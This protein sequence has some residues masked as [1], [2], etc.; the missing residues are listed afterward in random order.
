MDHD[1][2]AQLDG[3]GTLSGD[4]AAT[5]PPAPAVVLPPDPRVQQLAAL[6]EAMFTGALTVS[7]DGKSTTFRDLAAMRTLVAMLEGELG[8]RRGGAVVVR[9]RKGW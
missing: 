1:G 3:A 7:Y 6:K 2:A 8:T 9:A 4:A 5:S